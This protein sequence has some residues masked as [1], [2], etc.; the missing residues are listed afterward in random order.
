[1]SDAKVIDIES[2]RL[3]RDL[4]DSLDIGACIKRA[5]AMQVA[6]SYLSACGLTERA[7]ATRKEAG[8]IMRHAEALYAMGEDEEAV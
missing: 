7:E 3:E 8:R 1:M 2:K 5:A 6:A 4:D